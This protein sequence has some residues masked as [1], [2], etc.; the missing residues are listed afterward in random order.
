MT[1]N[2][3]TSALDLYAKVEDILGVKEVAPKLYAHYLLTLQTIE[4]ETLLDVGCGSGDFLSSMSGIFDDATMQGIDLS[5]LM[6]ERTKSIGVNASCIDLCDMDSSFDVITA[7]F[8]MLNYLDTKSLKAFLIC[9]SER[10]NPDGY[11]LCD[12][13]TLYGFSEVAVGS[14]IADEDDRFL[15]IDSD[16]E[17]GVYSSEF[18]LF[19]QNGDSYSKSKEQIS[20]YYHDSEMIASISGLELVTQESVSLY[21]DESDKTFLVFKKI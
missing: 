6:V 4:F 14:F 13:N 2:D 15:T 9:L 18:T 5:P 8:D 20:Q 1:L 12:I 7:T 21:G 16:F 11:F 3:N 17:D 10:L 19:E